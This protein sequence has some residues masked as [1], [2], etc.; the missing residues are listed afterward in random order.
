MASSC[1]A[2]PGR[3]LMR[4]SATGGTPVAV[5]R[6]AAGGGHVV[7]QFLPDGQHVLFFSVTGGQQQGVV[8]VASLDGGDPTR[9][10]GSTSAAAYAPPGY[11]MRVSQ[12]VLVAQRF[13]A[14][15]ATLSGD[16]IPVAQAVVETAGFRGAF[17]VSA[18]LLA[19]RSGVGG[20]QRQ[21]VWVD[22]T[23][24][25][26]G[27]VGPPDEAAPTSF[28]LSPDGQRVANARTAQ[29]NYDVWLTDV[30]RSVAT[31]F[32][33]DPAAEFSPVWSPDGTRVVF[34]SVNRSG[35]GPSD[36]FV[37]PANGAT[38][39]QP[40]LVDSQPKTPLDWSRD[41]RFLLYAQGDPK[42]Q[43]DLWA[44][45]LNGDAKPFAVVQ[46]AF[47]ETQ[48]QFSPDGHWLA[49]TS[50]E[51][52]RDDVY[53]RPFPDA[54]G[55]WQVSTGGGSQPRWRPDGKELF[56]VATDGKLM[57]VPIDVTPQSRAVTPGTPAALFA[58][59][60][61][62]GAG[63]SLSGYQSRALYAV[64]ADGRFLMNV[65]IEAD[66]AAP[67]TIVQNWDAALKK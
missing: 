42:T 33:F 34:R 3:G 35:R 52:G 14:A 9:V 10:V 8:S 24:K 29:G 47:D 51:S 57:A 17:S 28:A 23:G 13:D 16:P 12:G 18:G 19:H 36:L 31:R 54:G 21:L 55:K 27:T 40:F 44:L 45:P 26:L 1:S 46:T 15:H 66:H 67:I 56:Y 38:D 32:T 41:E 60:L 48:G 50:N 20:G 22:R 25:V 5:T 39:E 4:V 43:S 61:A 62:N 6:P 53:V 7:P 2:G 58:T 59:H 37:K 65:T 64:A 11:L 49:Y 30:A 63:I